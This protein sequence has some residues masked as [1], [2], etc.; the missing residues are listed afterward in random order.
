[1]AVT[2]L[3]VR[4]FLAQANGAIALDFANRTALALTTP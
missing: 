1:L 2:T 4:E 3:N